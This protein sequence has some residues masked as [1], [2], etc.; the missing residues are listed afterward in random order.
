MLA[1]S[2]SKSRVFV[3]VPATAEVNVCGGSQISDFLSPRYMEKNS[4][5]LKGGVLEPPPLQRDSRSVTL[6]K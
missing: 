3:S 2:L 5:V 4:A 6:G 1:L